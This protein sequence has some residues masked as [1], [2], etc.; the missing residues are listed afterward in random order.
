M[1]LLKRAGELAPDTSTKSGLMLGLGELPGELRRVLGDLVEV[2]C[3]ILTL[4]QYLQPSASHLPVGGGG[5][6]PWRCGSARF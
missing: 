3:R 6:W 1:L 2:G 5:R 4:G